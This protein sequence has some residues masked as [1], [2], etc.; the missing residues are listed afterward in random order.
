MLNSKIVQKVI[1]NMESCNTSN[2]VVVMWR[3]R[4]WEKPAKGG[5]K[6]ACAISCAHT[7]EKGKMKGEKEV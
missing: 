6:R 4:V 5:S 7:K 3:A 2:D 1:S